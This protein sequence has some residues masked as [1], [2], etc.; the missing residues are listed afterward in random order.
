MNH[1]ANNKKKIPF[2]KKGK[3]RVT[4]AK[5]VTRSPRVFPSLLSAHLAARDLRVLRPP[6]PTRGV[7]QKRRTYDDPRGISS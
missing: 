4:R 1:S 6:P 3:S 5:R 2:L 7:M